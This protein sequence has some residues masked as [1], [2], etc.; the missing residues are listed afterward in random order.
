MPGIKEQIKKL[1][2]ANSNNKDWQ[3]LSALIDEV[4]DDA[5]LIC[6]SD[7]LEKEVYAVN[8]EL[9]FRRV[10]LLLVDSKADKMKVVLPAWVKQQ[11]NLDYK[12]DGTKRDDDR[13]GSNRTESRSNSI[14]HNATTTN[15]TIGSGVIRVDNANENADTKRRNGDSEGWF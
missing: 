10:C 2:T 8:P 6:K 3:V 11:L 13:A 4:S 5:L 9:S 14:R 1:L 7:I 12:Y 15:L